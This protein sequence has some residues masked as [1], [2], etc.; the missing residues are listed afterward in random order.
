MCGSPSVDRPTREARNPRAGVVQSRFNLLLPFLYSRSRRAQLLPEPRSYV[1]HKVLL[2]MHDLACKL[3]SF[4]IVKGSPRDGY[5][6]LSTDHAS[7]SAGE[8]LPCFI[9]L[10][11]ITAVPQS[12]VF[13]LIAVLP[14]GSNAVLLTA[15]LALPPQSEFN[16]PVSLTFPAGFPLGTWRLVSAL[17]SP[18][19][20]LVDASVMQFELE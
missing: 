12:Y 14:S 17:F 9:E 16:L 20:V 3:D 7:T 1:P 5:T 11:N 6:R 18:T 19:G 15:P 10:E 8:S 13:A 4:T 2:L